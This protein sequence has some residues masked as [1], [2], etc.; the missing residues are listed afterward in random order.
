LTHYD[1][2]LVNFYNSEHI[3]V[4]SKF[5][6][7]I[8]L[9]IGTSIGGGM[10]ALPVSNAPVGFAD[11]TLFLVICWLAMT[12]GALLILEVTLW[13]P[14]GGNLIS[15]AGKTLGSPG[16][17][18]VWI[19]FLLL[20]YAFLAAYISGGPDALQGFL[21]AIQISSPP[22]TSAILFSLLLG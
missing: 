17:I 13:L 6:G 2:V 15:M 22:A 18:V 14:S 8:L 21:N 7:G 5:I 4:D 3:M 10:L 16:K 20:L 19:L 9:I 11:S 1:K 12:L